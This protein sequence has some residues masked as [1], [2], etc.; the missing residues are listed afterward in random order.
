[1]IAEIIAWNPIADGEFPDDDQTV[2]LHDST[3][4][5]DTP[6]M[7]GYLDGDQWMTEDDRKFWTYELPTH[8]AKMPEGPI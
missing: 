4:G 7:V 2:L 8:W 5:W 1:M 3:G 6:V